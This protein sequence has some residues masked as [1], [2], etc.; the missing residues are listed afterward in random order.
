MN[1]TLAMRCITNAA[2][3]SLA[4]VTFSM[5]KR[6]VVCNTGMIKKVRK[7]HNIDQRILGLLSIETKSLE[8]RRLSRR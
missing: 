2:Y 3:S 4:K 1:S 6:Y 5:L 8:K 7:F